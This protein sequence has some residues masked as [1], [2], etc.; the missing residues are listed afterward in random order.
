MHENFDIHPPEVYRARA[1]GQPRIEEAHPAVGM[2]QEEFEQLEMFLKHVL[3]EATAR[4]GPSANTLFNH[5]QRVKQ[6]VDQVKERHPAL[7]E[8]VL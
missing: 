7:K 6:M 3:A 5:W 1:T 4:G 8:R 2:H